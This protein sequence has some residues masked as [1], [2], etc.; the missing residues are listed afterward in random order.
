MTSSFESPVSVSVCSVCPAVL[1]SSAPLYT[2]QLACSLESA[3]RQAA[4]DPGPVPPCFRGANS[5]AR[6]TSYSTNLSGS[7]EE[8]F[9]P[10]KMI[11]FKLNISQVEIKT[12]ELKEFFT[13]LKTVEHKLLQLKPVRLLRHDQLSGLGINVWDFL[14]GEMYWHFALPRHGPGEK[15]HAEIVNTDVG[16]AVE[17]LPPCNSHPRSPPPPPAGTQPAHSYM[18]NVI[19][20]Y[21][22]C[23]FVSAVCPTAQAISNKLRVG[24]PH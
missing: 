2:S 24:H 22:C 15:L 1:R 23:Y 14:A 4:A 18:V 8:I 9:W 10:V 17:E 5:A 6:S 3:A 20:L 7:T 12:S 11:E 16:G 13:Y 21:K 19:G